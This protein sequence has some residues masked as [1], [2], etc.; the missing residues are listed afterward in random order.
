MAEKKSKVIKQQKK[1]IK[2]LKAR[3]NEL[4]KDI[5]RLQDAAHAG[6]KFSE[7]EVEIAEETTEDAG[8]I[9]EIMEKA[10]E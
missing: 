1:Q 8:E 7:S 5:K 6:Q 10:G 2:K 3:N 4:K 9:E